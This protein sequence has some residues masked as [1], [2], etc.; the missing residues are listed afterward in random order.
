MSSSQV[1]CPCGSLCL[2]VSVLVCSFVC[3]YASVCILASLTRDKVRALCVWLWGNMPA[4]MQ[5]RFHARAFMQELP[6]STQWDE[7]PCSHTW[8]AWSGSSGM[9]SPARRA[10]LTTSSGTV[11]C[12]GRKHASA[13]LTHLPGLP[14]PADCL[15][16]GTHKTLLP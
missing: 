9:S 2:Y 7:C 5:K 15:A 6:C 8:K 1:L 12:D 4:G 14:D 10:T 3:L 13:M 16:A 11:T